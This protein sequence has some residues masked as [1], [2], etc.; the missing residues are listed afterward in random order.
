M[1]VPII[2]MSCQTG[3]HGHHPYESRP[4]VAFVLARFGPLFF[5][6]IE[7]LKRG[8]TGHSDK[9][10]TAFVLGLGAQKFVG[11]GCASKRLRSNHEVGL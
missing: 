8:T 9:L 3:A 5:F 11:R 10:T 1:G 2:S 6:P 4:T 7:V